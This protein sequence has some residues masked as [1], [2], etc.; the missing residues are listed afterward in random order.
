MIGLAI[1][2]FLLGFICS[3]AAAV[4]LIWHALKDMWR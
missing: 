1:F 4:I 2:C 3:A